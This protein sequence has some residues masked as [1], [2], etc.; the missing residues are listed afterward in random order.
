V[1][2]EA[3]RN[4]GLP[5][6]LAGSYGTREGL[7]EALSAGAAGIQLGTAFAFSAESGLVSDL[8]SAIIE[9][10]MTGGVEV[11]SDWRVSPTGFPFRVVQ[12]EGTLSDE[13]VYAERRRVCDL[14]ALRTPYKTENGQIGYRCPAEPLAAYSRIKGGRE[15]NTEGRSC[16]C[17]GLLATAGLPQYRTRA[18]Y[19]E[20]PIVTAGSDFRAIGDLMRGV[21]DGSAFYSA[22]D[23]IDYLLQP[24]PGQSTSRPTTKRRP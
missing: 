3:L 22:G 15:Q 6:W 4:I 1:D 17:N 18:A 20:P 21:P 9:Q 24:A 16:L 23:V 8:K 5:F 11:W 10:A 14:G 12:I 7:Q 13:Q 19:E 2:L